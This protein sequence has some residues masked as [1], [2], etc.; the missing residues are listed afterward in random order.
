MTPGAECPLD[1]LGDGRQIQQSVDRRVV[2]MDGCGPTGHVGY[3]IRTMPTDHHAAAAASSGDRPRRWAFALVCLTYGTATV[4][5]QLLSPL[6][7]TARRD[8]G[9]TTGQGG[10]AFAVLAVER[11]NVLDLGQR[12]LQVL[13]H[14][15]KRVRQFTH[16]VVAQV[17]DAVT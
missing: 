13:G 14:A 15:V 11:K 6:F 4:G 16:F 8:L 17:A 3:C 12:L 7:P 5:E 2:E 10:V 1:D 9:L